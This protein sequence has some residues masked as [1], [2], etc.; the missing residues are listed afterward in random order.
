MM[1][2]LETTGQFRID[3]KRVKKRGFDMNLL[4]WTDSVNPGT[5]LNRRILQAIQRKC[6]RA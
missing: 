5:Q 6:Y 2:Q 4:V 1:L 3:Y